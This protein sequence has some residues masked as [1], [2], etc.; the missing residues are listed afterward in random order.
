MG[1]LQAYIPSDMDLLGGPRVTSDLGPPSDIAPPPL[2][3][4]VN[5]TSEV[6]C[7]RVASLTDI[8][9]LFW[10]ASTCSACMR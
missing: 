7:S 5:G 6:R 10:D 2:N 9:V 1:P 8:H 4:C 3:H